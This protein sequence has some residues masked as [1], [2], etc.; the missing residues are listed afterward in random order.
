MANNKVLNQDFELGGKVGKMCE[1]GLQHFQLNNHVP[2]QLAARGVGEGTVISEFLNLAD[3][4][5]KSP[6]Q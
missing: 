5:Q 4:V 1:F 6:G 3:V 2:Q